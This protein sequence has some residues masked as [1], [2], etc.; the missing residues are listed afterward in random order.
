MVVSPAPR[1]SFTAGARAIAPLLVAAFPFGLV[2][3]VAVTQSSV[4]NWQGG[5]ASAL[6]VAGAAQ[7]ALIDLIDEGA[8]WIIAVGTALIINLRFAMYSAALAPAFGPFPRRWQLTLPYLM[9]DQAAVTAL[10]N[11][12][13]HDD[14]VHRRWFYLGAA[15][16]F[17][18]AWLIGTWLG[19]LFGGDIPDSW[20]LGF[21]VPLVFIA[22]AVPAVRNRPA[23]VAAVVGGAGCLL[24]APLPHSLG[25]I[26]GAVAGVT[27]GLG[28][29][30]A[31]HGGMTT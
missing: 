25:V 5:V 11:F 22:L 18:L 16:P 3:G 6:V 15:V 19:I 26:V 14:P 2:Y 20:Q 29:T 7:F 31:Q 10:L 12:E 27:A 21:A 30:R 9:T 24:A 13:S 4:T 28:S 17:T 23:L 1:A 8:P